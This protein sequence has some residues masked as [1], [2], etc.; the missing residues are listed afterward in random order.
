MQNNKTLNYIRQW[1]PQRCLLICTSSTSSSFFTSSFPLT[2]SSLIS[3]DLRFWLQNKC[4]IYT[5]PLFLN[6]WSFQL[7]IYTY[8]TYT[9]TLENI[10]KI[11]G[12]FPL[13]L[14]TLAL[15]GDSRSGW[16]YILTHWFFKTH[17]C[18]IKK[19]KGLLFES[20][21]D[22]LLRPAFP[23][24]GGGDLT[25]SVPMASSSCSSSWEPFEK[26]FVFPT[27]KSFSRWSSFPN[28]AFT[29]DMYTS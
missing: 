3:S 16:F 7:C 1:R 14:V 8:K 18:I 22:L 6:K 24:E 20:P 10:D 15:A 28:K 12:C 23:L 2:L 4:N 21:L 5:L 29:F 11:V 17:D 19:K 13:F 27:S 9:H 25:S 26:P